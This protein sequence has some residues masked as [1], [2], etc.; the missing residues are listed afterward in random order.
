[1]VPEIL[2]RTSLKCEDSREDVDKTYLTTSIQTL[3][4]VS[5]ESLPYGL[6]CAE[7]C[8]TSKYKVCKDESDYSL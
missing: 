5:Q 3:C 8:G 1:M 2:V 7:T 4:E 6:T